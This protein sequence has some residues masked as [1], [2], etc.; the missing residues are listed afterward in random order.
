MNAILSDV[1]RGGGTQLNQMA[2]CARQLHIWNQSILHQCE[3]LHEQKV[4]REDELNLGQYDLAKPAWAP[5]VLHTKCFTHHIFFIERHTKNVLH[6]MLYRTSYAQ[7]HLW[8]ILER[9]SECE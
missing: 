1:V 4:G 6:V 7:K 8:R 3:E 5:N 2:Q 9:I